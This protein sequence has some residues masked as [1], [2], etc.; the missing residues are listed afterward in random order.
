MRLFLEV[1]YDGAAYHGWQVQNNALSVQEVLEN[2][3][4]TI[5]G[6]ECPTVC[7]GRTDTGVHCRSQMVH[8][9]YQGSL[10]LELM[11]RKLNGYLPKDIA[12]RSIRPVV[13]DAHARFS[14]TFRA[15]EYLITTAKNPFL[16]DF[17]Y[18]LPRQLDFEN[19]ERATTLLLGRQDFECFSRV[20]TS[21]NNFWCDIHEASWTHEGPLLKFNI[22][23]NRFLRGMVRAIVGT[24]LEVGKG[25]VPIDQFQA[26][27]HSRDRKKAGMA[28]PAQGLYLVEVGFPEEIFVDMPGARASEEK[29]D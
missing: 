11:Q 27:L 6:Q 3:L 19:M 9:D 18:F 12:I 17:A 10:P 13:A 2:A 22:R 24:L 26:I 15:Y 4:R 21:V 7:S 14:A 25:T 16:R 23:A 5:L 29:N 8:F 28:A 1:A 20:K